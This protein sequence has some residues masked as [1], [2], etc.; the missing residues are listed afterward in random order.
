MNAFP[1]ND[2]FYRDHESD[3]DSEV[4]DEIT[5]TTEF[6]TSIREFKDID[7]E[8]LEY[9]KKLRELRKLKKQREV[10]IIDFM[11]NIDEEAIEMRDGYL[12]VHKTE[13]KVSLSMKF[14]RSLVIEVYGDNSKLDKFMELV[15]NRPKKDYFSLKMKKS[16]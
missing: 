13:R 9:S 4:E 10:Y 2:E 1:D 15:Q 12:A 8:I 16:I 7:K 6:Q 5:I 11:K 14:L 3:N